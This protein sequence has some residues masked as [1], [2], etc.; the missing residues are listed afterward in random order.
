MVAQA[1]VVAIVRVLTLL[2]TSRAVS[3]E[4][5]GCFVSIEKEKQHSVQL[6]LV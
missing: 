3:I 1:F 4:T 2:T 5:L 6:M